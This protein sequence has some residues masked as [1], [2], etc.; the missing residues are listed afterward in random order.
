MRP[1]LNPCRLNC[2]HKALRGL[3]CKND[4]P[5]IKPFPSDCPR[6]AKKRLEW[7]DF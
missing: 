7:W 1:M 2:E 6:Y 3:V 4:S 5:T